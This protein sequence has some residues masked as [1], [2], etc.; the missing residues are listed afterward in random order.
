MIYCELEKAHWSDA[1]A[2][3]KGILPWEEAAPFERLG[4]GCP[5]SFTCRTICPVSRLRAELLDLARRSRW[6]PYCMVTC[7]MVT[8]SQSLTRYYYCWQVFAPLFK[9]A[10]GCKI[11]GYDAA[12]LTESTRNPSAHWKIS[13]VQKMS[14][15]LRSYILCQLCKPRHVFICAWNMRSGFL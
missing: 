15:S 8:K 2:W 6:K 10:C 9:R 11:S 14:P 5:S 1:T 4:L 3:S 7:R 13:R 12:F